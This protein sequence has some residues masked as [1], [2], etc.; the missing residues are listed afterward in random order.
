RIEFYKGRANA[1]VFRYGGG[2][3]R[4][5]GGDIVLSA[6]G[7]NTPKQFMLLGIGG[8]TE[9]KIHKNEGVFKIP[10]VGGQQQEHPYVAI[11]YRSKVPTYNLT[12]GVLQKLSIAAK[13]LF[14]REGPLAGAYEAVA[15]LKTDIT[16]PVPEVQLFFAPIGWGKTDGSH[17]LLS[18]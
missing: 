7:I 12:Q 2:G 13:Y 18:F 16:A 5:T 10:P 9:H 3:D 4:E 15:F 17:R 14:H 6:G 1:V 8:S 11:S